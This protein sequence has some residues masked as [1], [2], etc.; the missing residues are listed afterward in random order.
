M[1][2]R[3]PESAAVA[4]DEE[5]IRPLAEVR[6]HWS[7]FLPTPIVAAVYGGAWLYVETT[8]LAGGA[9]ARLL[10]LVMLLAPPLLLAYAFLRYYSTGAA[11]TRHHLLLS[12][13]WPHVGG[14]EIA[15]SEIEAVTVRETWLGRLLGAGTLHVRLRDGGAIA[16]RDLAAPG[17]FAAAV[18]ARLTRRR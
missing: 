3:Q 7:L 6:A 8:A 10:F 5:A 4:P 2:S 16:T 1:V 17:D 15:L 12:R 11:L 13:G 9:L 14:E 18:T